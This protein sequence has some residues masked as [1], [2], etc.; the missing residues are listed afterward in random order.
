MKLFTSKLPFIFVSLGL[1]A[2]N[3][4]S[5]N[6]K[7]DEYKNFRDPSKKYSIRIIGDKLFAQDSLAVQKDINSINYNKKE[8]LHVIAKQ[9][10]TRLI[11]KDISLNIVVDY[12]K[13]WNN[14]N[15]Y[16]EGSE[17]RD[18]IQELFKDV[19]E[20]YILL[21]SDSRIY[22]SYEFYGRYKNRTVS[23]SVMRFRLFE[24]KNMKTILE[25]RE[26]IGIDMTEIKASENLCELFVDYILSNN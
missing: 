26:L 11:E 23:N 2:L 1:L 9:I 3:S 5:Y 17:P 6:L 12:R 19:N 16:S 4:C 18:K 8:L 24:R 25:I 21:L 14:L 10:G 7:T 22:E 20:D 13:D 15:D